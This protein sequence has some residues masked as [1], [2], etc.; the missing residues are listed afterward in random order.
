VKRVWK[1]ATG[2]EVPDGA[3][4]LG[5]VVQTEVLVEGHELTDLSGP[6]AGQTYRTDDRWEH[7]W[8]IWHY[9]EVEA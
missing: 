8:L 2:Q 3:V 4:Y 5:S 9:Y 7:C 6:S 1:Y